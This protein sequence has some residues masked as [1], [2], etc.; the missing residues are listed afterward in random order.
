MQQQSPSQVDQN[1]THRTLDLN[2]IKEANLCREHEHWFL[3]RRW[4]NDLMWKTQWAAQTGRTEPFLPVRLSFSHVKRRHT[5]EEGNSRC[6]SGGQG[7]PWDA[8]SVVDPSQC[9]LVPPTPAEQ[10]GIFKPWDFL[11]SLKFSQRPRNQH[12]NFLIVRKNFSI[13]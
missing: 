2:R 3:G 7:R 13:I 11:N 6:W 9:M 10:P 4:K 12:L 5:S 1:S 8:G